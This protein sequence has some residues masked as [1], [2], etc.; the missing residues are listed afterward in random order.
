MDF[1][2]KYNLMIVCK[3]LLYID[4]TSCLI[5]II[6]IIMYFNKM[7]CFVYLVFMWIINIVSRVNEMLI[8]IIVFV[9]IV[10]S[11]VDFLIYILILNI[12]YKTVICLKLLN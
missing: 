9:L 10:P 4:F 8:N 5:I 3:K 2:L 6:I 1:V 7:R 12:D 11:T